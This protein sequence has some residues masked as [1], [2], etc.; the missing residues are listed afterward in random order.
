MFGA[1]YES[2]ASLTRCCGSLGFVTF[3]AQKNTTNEKAPDKRLRMTPS[4]DQIAVHRDFF[5]TLLSALSVVI[6]LYLSNFD[7]RFILN[8]FFVLYSADLSR[9]VM[10][11]GPP[12]EA[13]SSQS[14]SNSK[15]K[16]AISSWGDEC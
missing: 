13:M 6:A 4:S 16:P 1:I 11:A 14:K 7:L 8:L 12:D 5:I 15:S 10:N 3:C 9:I 2:F